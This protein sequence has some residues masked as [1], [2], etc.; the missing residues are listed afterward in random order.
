M[1]RFRTGRPAGRGRGSRVHRRRGAVDGRYGT[2]R[3]SRDASRHG[4]NRHGRRAR[5]GHSHVGALPARACP[6]E[7]AGRAGEAVVLRHHAVGFEAMSCASCHSPA[8][9]YGPPNGR[10]VQLG[11]PRLRSAGTRAVPSLRYLD[12]TPLFSLHFFT[13][14]SEDA[15]YEGPTGGFTSDG[16]VASR[17]QQAAMPLLNANEMANADPAAAVAA[18]RD[19]SHARP[20]AHVFGT[21]I[22]NHPAVPSPTSVRRWRRSRPRIPA[23]TP[24]PASSTR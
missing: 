21:D 8:H 16:A 10:A 4:S 23:S 3:H 5:R 15:E 20:S 1:P 11:G 17:Q 2:C 22:F 24:T 19:G 14:G 7:R 18:V 12:H 6:A 13:P 9:A